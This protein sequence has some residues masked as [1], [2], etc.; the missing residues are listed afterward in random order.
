MTLFDLLNYCIPLLRQGPI[1]H[2]R[3]IRANHR[4]M[5]GNNN[6]VE[7]VGRLKLRCLGFSGTS[8]PGQF[9]VQTEI[10][11]QRDRRERLILFLDHYALFGFHGL[12]Q[13]V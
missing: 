10:V 3:E 11:L 9:L 12:V 6:H 7:F 1:D 13:S 8:H 4:H 5:G 2:V